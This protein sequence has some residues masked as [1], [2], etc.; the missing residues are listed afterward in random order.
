[1]ETKGTLGQSARET[2]T[3]VKT[4]VTSTAARAKEEAS[5]LASDGKERTVGRINSY[6]EALHDSARSLEEKDPNIAW[7]AHQAA[8]KLQGVA[9]Y[10]RQRNMADLRY[11]A[12]N[13]ARRHPAIFFGGL[14]VAGLV[15]GNVIKASRRRVETDSDYSDAQSGDWP[16]RQSDSTESMAAAD[17]PESARSSAGI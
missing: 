2:A 11:E 13:A 14:F 7:F 17:L 8:D 9:D 15:L 3:K 6:G 12:E 10:L 5:R 1:M 4:A 16:Q